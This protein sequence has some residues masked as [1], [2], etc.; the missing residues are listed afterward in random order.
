MP[1]EPTTLK[2]W[3][4]FFIIIGMI[5]T[6]IFILLCLLIGAFIL[7]KPWGVDVPQTISAIVSPPTQ[8]T[9]Y[10]HPLLNPQ[11]EA[12]L[13]SVGVDVKSLPTQITKDQQQ[14]AIDAVGQKRAAEL[15]GGSAPTLSDITKLKQCL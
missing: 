4:I 11:Q 5:S 12:I 10:D 15:L 3:H 7:I 8:S 9:G 6:A 2:A 1:K 14:C 13:E